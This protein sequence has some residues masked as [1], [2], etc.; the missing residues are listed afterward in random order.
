MFTFLG[1]LALLIVVLIYDLLALI[2]RLFGF[3]WPFIPSGSP[4]PLTKDEKDY[5]YW[6][7]QEKRKNRK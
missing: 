4:R 1:I 3:D 5:F 7:E 2:M 6:Q